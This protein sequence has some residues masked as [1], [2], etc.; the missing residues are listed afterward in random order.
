MSKRQKPLVFFDGSVAGTWGWQ[1]PCVSADG[2]YYYPTVQEAYDAAARHAA[3]W[4]DGGDLETP[5]EAEQ[6]DVH[7]TEW[8]PCLLWAGHGGDH[9]YWEPR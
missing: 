4:H 3:I 5:C 8:L 9:E 1:C 2:G 6:R 7:G